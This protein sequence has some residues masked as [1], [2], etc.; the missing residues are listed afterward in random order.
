VRAV[1]FDPAVVRI[2]ARQRVGTTLVCLSFCGGGTGAYRAWAG[3]LADT[4]DLALVCYPGREG[5]FAEPR[6]THWDQLVEDA[7]GVVRG[8]VDGDYLL[9][10]HSMGGWVA[11]D[12]V[13]TLAAGGDRMPNALVVSA[14]NAPYR[15]LTERDRFPSATDSDEQLL[16][17]M[18]IGG[19]L[20]DYVREDASLTD[21]AVDL[22]RSDIAVRD[23]YH[24]RDGTVVSVPVQVLHGGDDPVIDPAVGAE[25]GAV[26]TAGRTVTELPG[27]HFYT[28]DVWAT[29]PTW[30]ETPVPTRG[31]GRAPA[32]SGHE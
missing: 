3:G 18:T 7:A 4:M 2:P 13:A 20:P 11:F 28:P 29:L 19:L 25:W 22:M 5:R 24:Y 8:A 9:F 17:W 6:P 10:G 1:T 15:G 32:R 30:I 12:V 26:C 14:C 21:M 27:G 31:W 23:T 16:E